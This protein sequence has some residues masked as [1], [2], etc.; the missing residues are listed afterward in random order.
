MLN[1]LLHEAVP[2]ILHEDDQN[3]MYYSI[4]NRSPFLDRELCEYAARIPTRHLVRDGYAKAV[5]REAVRGIVADPILDCD[6]KVGFNAPIEAFLDF[7]DPQ[8]VG[9]LLDDGPIFAQV[10][11]E[12]IAGLLGKRALPN[13]ESKFLFNFLCSRIFLDQHA[14]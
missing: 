6:R 3:A 12:K 13:S 14:G 9:Q 10:Q 2:V 7:G 1:E 8:V 5:L 11:R 4:E